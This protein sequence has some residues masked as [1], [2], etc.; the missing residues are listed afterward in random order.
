MSPSPES[1]L[2]S[3]SQREHQALQNLVDLAVE[4]MSASPGPRSLGVPAGETLGG[5]VGL[6]MQSEGLGLVRG[7]LGGSVLIP[8]QWRM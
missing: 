3:S 5:V 4:G 7:L 1:Q 8:V 6:P 2:L